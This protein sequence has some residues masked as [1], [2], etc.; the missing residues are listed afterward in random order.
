MQVSQI[1]T[2]L[3]I[4]FMHPLNPLPFA[5]K[6]GFLRSLAQIILNVKP[7]TRGVVV[8]PGRPGVDL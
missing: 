3:G 7:N 4:G 1:R 5:V 8:E 2:G 6:M